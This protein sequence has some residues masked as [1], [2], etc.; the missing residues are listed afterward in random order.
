MTAAYISRTN[1]NV[2]H[3]GGRKRQ[4]PPQQP[5]GIPVDKL[6]VNP[7]DEKGATAETLKAVPDRPLSPKGVQGV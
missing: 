4:L 7:I 3:A 6:D 1:A 5:R 2:R